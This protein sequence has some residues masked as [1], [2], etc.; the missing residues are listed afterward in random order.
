M[1]CELH[2]IYRRPEGGGD[3][4]PPPPKL[5]LLSEPA[6]QRKHNLGNDFTA[7]HETHWDCDCQCAEQAT[8]E[9][10]LCWGEDCTAAATAK[11]RSPSST[12]AN[13]R[14]GSWCHHRNQEY[15]DGSPPHPNFSSA[16]F[17]NA[18]LFWSMKS[19]AS[20]STMPGSTACQHVIASLVKLPKETAL[21]LAT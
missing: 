7:Y 15:R 16:G 5:M 14:L 12:S 20:S 17:C 1:P 10:I 11:S 13:T 9:L 18:A 4:E 3:P 21:L 19:A 6:H 8:Q 2:E